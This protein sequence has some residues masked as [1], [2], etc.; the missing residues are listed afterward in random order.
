MDKLWVTK[1]LTEA[2]VTS[3]HVACSVCLRVK[4]GLSYH[5]KHKQHE[6]MTSLSGFILNICPLNPCTQ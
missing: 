1:S 2:S 3:E 6:L 4:D 5:E